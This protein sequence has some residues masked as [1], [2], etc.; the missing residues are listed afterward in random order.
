MKIHLKKFGMFYIF[1][2]CMQF[3]KS[4]LFSSILP[5]LNYHKTIITK[6]MLIIGDATLCADKWS[7]KDFTLIDL[8]DEL[9]VTLY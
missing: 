2:F 7:N 3:L 9:K 6:I 5:S 8:A 1:D 4:L